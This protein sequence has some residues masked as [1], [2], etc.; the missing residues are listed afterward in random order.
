MIS[1][2]MAPKGQ[3]GK[4]KASTSQKGQ[5]RARKDQADSCSLQVP[6]RT[7]GINWVLEDEGKEWHRN[8]KVKRYVHVD[9]MQKESLAKNFPRILANIMALKLDFIF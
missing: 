9:S 7:F 6:Q 4:K 8:N 3:Q 2:N 5:K 1:G